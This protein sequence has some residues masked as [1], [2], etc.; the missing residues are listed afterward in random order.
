MKQTIMEKLFNGKE[1]STEE[2]LFVGKNLPDIENNVL[3]YDH[4]NDNS[5]TACGLTKK[6]V[7][8]VNKKF[9]ELQENSPEKR[10]SKLVELV[11][12][13]AHVDPLLLRMLVFQAIKAGTA[14]A[15]HFAMG[16]DLKDITDDMPEALKKL[17]E[18]IIKRKMDED[19]EDPE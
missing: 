18:K 8:R 14:R 11:E 13:D 6:D 9:R 3:P 1:L 10:V 7:D 19:E 16:S 4:E 5:L 12:C 2:I 17:I 15:I